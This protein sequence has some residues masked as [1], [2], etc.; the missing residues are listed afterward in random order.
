[1]ETHRLSLPLVAG[2]VVMGAMVG[3]SA[4]FVG[5]GGAV[6][7]PLGVAVL[8]LAVLRFIPLRLVPL[9]FS[10]LVFVVFGL[11]LI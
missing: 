5:G 2:A 8:R 11:G 7:I 9:R 10:T 4:V 6:F 1:V 3:L